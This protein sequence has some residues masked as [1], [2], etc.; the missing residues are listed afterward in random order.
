MSKGKG[1][2]SVDEVVKELEQKL[3][4]NKPAMNPL[5]GTD[6]AG[7]KLAEISDY[8]PGVKEVVVNGIKIV[9]EDM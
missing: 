9:R 7:V 8:T 6:A 1:K 3:G 2:E 4:G 5:P